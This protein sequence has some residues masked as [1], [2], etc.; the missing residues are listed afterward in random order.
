[1]PLAE[2][3]RPVIWLR[4]SENQRATAICTAAVPEKTVDAPIS[5][6][7]KNMASR[8][9]DPANAK[10]PAALIKPPDT[11]RDFSA[12][13]LSSLWKKAAANALPTP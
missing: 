3:T 10:Y 8:R 11:I 1:M 13:R 4:R 12:K 7:P 6:P 2:A 5:T 9:L